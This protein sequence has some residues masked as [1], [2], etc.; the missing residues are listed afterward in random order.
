RF[1][2]LAWAYSSAWLE[3]F[4]DKE[5]VGGSSPPRPTKQGRENLIARFDGDLAQ[6][7]EHLLCKQGV[8]GSIPLVST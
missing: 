6:L 5:E 3:R 1:C 8:R 4:P 2:F 7:V